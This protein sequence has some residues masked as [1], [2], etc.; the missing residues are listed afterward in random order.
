ML[1]QSVQNSTLASSRLQR[2]WYMTTFMQL[3]LPG[4]TISTRDHYVSCR[5]TVLIW[6]DIGDIPDI[7]PH[8]YIVPHYDDVIMSAIASQIT[9]LTI[10][11]S[12][13]YPGADQ[14]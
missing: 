1:H 3:D 2:H 8:P 14:S 4:A 6:F 10:V 7:S 13:V 11:Y 5:F 9:S 12:T